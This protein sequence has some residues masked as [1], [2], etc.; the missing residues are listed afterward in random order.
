MVPVGE[1]GDRFTRC[2]HRDRIGDI[3]EPEPVVDIAMLAASES[4]PEVLELSH[5]S[6]TFHQRG[7]AIPAL[8]DIELGL[9][10]G[11]TLGIV[12]ESGSGKSTLA[13]TMLGIEAADSGGAVSLDGHEMAGSTTSRTA[14]D[15]RSMQMIFQNPDSALNRSWSVRRILVRSVTKLT[16]IK[17][18]EANARAIATRCFK[19]PDSWR[20]LRSR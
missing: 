12:G 4:Q 5:V 13:K 11:E 8:V 1:N 18:E 17:G 3:Q 10:E 20:G 14:A 16:G 6:K 19:P 15:K 2:H 9:A 7:H